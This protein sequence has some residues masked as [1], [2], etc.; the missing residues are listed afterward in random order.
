MSKLLVIGSINMDVTIFSARMPVAGET[1]SGTGFLLSPGGK[2]A[3]QAVAAARMGCRTAMVGCVGDDLFGHELVRSLTGHGIDT[4]PIEA[5]PG[6]STGVASITVVDGDNRIILHDGANGRVRCGE[7]T[8]R[9]IEA[10][11]A[12]MMQLEIPL[13]AV[14]ES[15]DVA[16]RLGKS[17]FLTPAPAVPLPE[18]LF[19]KIDYL[20][21]NESESSLL[22]GRELASDG[23]ILWALA[24]FR[25]LGV[26]EPVITLGERGVGCYIGGEPKIVRGYRVK[27]VDT[28]AAGDTFTGALA[29]CVLR[30]M[31]MADA[32]DFAQRA[33]AIS[34]TRKGAQNSVPTREEVL[35]ADLPQHP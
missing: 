9:L 20:L 8:E 33:A 29:A 31:P 26:K 16:H 10:S 32:V 17:V 18:A 14:L 19:G 21:P 12:V 15:V 5:L 6:V 28:T 25:A 1:I 30:G 35:A 27:P 13:H 24:R 4:A 2:G 22:L 11:D 34:C 23:D 3:N 7:G